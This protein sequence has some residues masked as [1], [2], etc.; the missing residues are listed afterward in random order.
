[1]YTKSLAVMYL[2]AVSPGSVLQ[3]TDIQSR[4]VIQPG[5]Y[6]NII[7]NGTIPEYRLAKT[8]QSRSNIGISLFGGSF[9]SHFV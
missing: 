1:N 2:S 5:A 4:S 6:R 3:A 7:S 8:N 9:L